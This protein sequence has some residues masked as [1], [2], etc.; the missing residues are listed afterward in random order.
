MTAPTVEP[1]LS[2]AQLREIFICD[3]EQGTL[4]WRERPGVVGNRRVA[5]KPAGALNTAGYRVV[6][7]RPQW[8]YVHRV[9]WAMAHGEWPTH[10]IDHVN[11]DRSDNRLANLREASH[12]EN[13]SNRG[14]QVNSQSGIKGVYRETFT[15]RWRASIQHEGKTYNLGRYD[16]PEAAQAAYRAA[17]ERFHGAFARTD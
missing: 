1:L 6:T 13:L 15:G 8:M 3:P 17:A 2:V 7:V 10:R 12:A 14:A 9:V 16:T 11:G 4:V 5:G